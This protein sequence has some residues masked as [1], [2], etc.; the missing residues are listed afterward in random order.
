MEI[1]EDKNCVSCRVGDTIYVHPN[2]KH[3]TELFR[4]LLT[5]EKGHSSSYTARDFYH[6]LFN[7]SVRKVRRKYYSF[8]LKNPRSMLFLFPFTKI[9][10]GWTFSF[11]NLLIWIMGLLVFAVIFRMF[12]L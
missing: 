12:T 7:D 10:G 6:D 2:L 11:N 4:E 5:H 9:G 8:M 1:K 3:D